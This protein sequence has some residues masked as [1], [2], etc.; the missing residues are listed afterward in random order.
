MPKEKGLLKMGEDSL[1][2]NPNHAL[3]S[4]FKIRCKLRVYKLVL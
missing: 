3:P 2:G 1:L 4:I